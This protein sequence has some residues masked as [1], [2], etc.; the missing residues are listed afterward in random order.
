MSIGFRDHEGFHRAAIAM[1]T[2]G[3]VAGGLG[4]VLGLSPLVGGAVGAGLGALV[5]ERRQGPARIGLALCAVAILA[6]TAGAFAAHRIAGAEAVATWPAWLVGILASAA[7]ALASV[8]ALVPAR[9]AIAR[10]A[11]AAAMRQLPVR[12]D[13]E[14]RDLAEQGARV[15][16]EVKTRLPAGDAGRALVEDGVLKLVDVAAR[17]EKIPADVAASRAKVVARIDEL[18]GRI[19]AATDEIARAQYGEAR[20]A[21]D[22]QRR[23]L[24]GIET[25]RQRLVARMHNYLA[26]LE[27]F[28]LCVIHVETASTAELEISGKALAELEA[29]A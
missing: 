12:V 15:W 27:K 13:A 3:A 14:V 6:A 10:D 26:A 11:V 18:D 25:S 16:T 23:Y 8:I 24:E 21:L 28:R 9:I 20:A 5:A 2:A 19:A 29:A 7:M 22:D 4:A 17:S 1:T